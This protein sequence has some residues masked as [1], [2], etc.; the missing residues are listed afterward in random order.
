MHAATAAKNHIVQAPTT[1]LMKRAGVIVP[2]QARQGIG[3]GAR[4]RITLGRAR[5]LTPQVVV[6]APQ[7]LLQRDLGQDVEAVEAALNTLPFRLA[8]P[9]GTSSSSSSRDVQQE[10]R[11][12]QRQHAPR[13]NNKT[14]CAWSTAPRGSHTAAAAAAA[15]AATEHPRRRPPKAMEQEAGWCLSGCRGRKATSNP[16]SVRDV[17]G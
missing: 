17:W 16:I 6:V 4:Q 12:P 15:A 9:H 13:A 7:A 8:P 5:S 2:A 10:A 3:A 11:P 1:Y 14:E